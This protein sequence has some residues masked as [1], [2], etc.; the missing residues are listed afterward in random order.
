MTGSRPLET[1]GFTTTSPR[2]RGAAAPSSQDEIADTYREGH[3]SP[4]VS[5]AA[6]LRCIRKRAD[7]MVKRFKEVWTLDR[8][9]QV[10]ERDVNRTVNAGC[11]LTQSLQ[12]S[13]R[14][15]TPL[16]LS[17]TPLVASLRGVGLCDTCVGD[18][19]DAPFLGRMKRSFQPINRIEHRDN[20]GDI[21]TPEFRFSDRSRERS[22]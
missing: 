7:N 11:Q 18:E 10:I 4:S 15:R 16:L 5:R 19:I 20:V 1:K 13:L 3:V 2:R 14:R 22:Q 17:G 12:P 9:R 21:E 8:Q 6:A